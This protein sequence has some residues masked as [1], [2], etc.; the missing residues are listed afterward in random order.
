MEPELSHRP[1]VEDGKPRPEKEGSFIYS[2]KGFYDKNTEPL[3]APRTAQAHIEAGEIRK[4]AEEFGKNLS[5]DPDMKV[6]IEKYREAQSAENRAKQEGYGALIDAKSGSFKYNLFKRLTNK[7]RLTLGGNKIIER[8]SKAIKNREELGN[9]II[10]LMWEKF[11]QAGLTQK[12]NI[13]W[14]GIKGNTNL[15][16]AE[17]VLGISLR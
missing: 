2:G 11:E 7:I 14:L 3:Y 1:G 12:P 13:F 15:S 16:R 4:V 17:E 10:S 6:L 8:G 9:Q 5:N